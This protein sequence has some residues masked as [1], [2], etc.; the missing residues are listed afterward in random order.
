MPDHFDGKL[1]FNTSGPIQKTFGD[2]L[3]WQIQAKRKRWPRWI[4]N[5]ARPAVAAST[6]VNEVVLTFINHVTFL[7]QTNGLNILTD[8]VF[9]KRASPFQFL[10][11]Q[12]VRP[13]GLALASLPKIDLVLISH[14]HYD[15]MDLETLRLLKERHSPVFLTPL[16]NAETLAKVGISNVIETDWWDQSQV[17]NETQ[18]VTVPAQHWSGRGLRDRNR[19][20]WAGFVIS[21]P[22]LKIYF[23]GDTGYAQHLLKIRER[24]GIMDISLLPIGAYEPR[25]FMRE[26]HMNP[27]DA[28]L[29]HRDLKSKLSIGMHFG[30]FQLTDEGIDDPVIDLKSALNKHHLRAFDVMEFGETRRIKAVVEPQVSV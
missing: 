24:L 23:A 8:P 3:K 9:S 25:W 30:T 2:F 18:I 20:L 19:A 6:S 7:V 29:A 10:G 16:R 4:E 21:T 22:R 5:S 15:H 13:P 11:P 17:T 27:D 14:N 1:F 28:V 26:Q 12:R